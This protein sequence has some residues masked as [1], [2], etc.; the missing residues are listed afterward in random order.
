[1]EYS[2]RNRLSVSGTPIEPHVTFILLLFAIGVFS[3]FVFTIF[4]ERA[5]RCS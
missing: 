3:L 2:F 5:G 1:V 4:Y